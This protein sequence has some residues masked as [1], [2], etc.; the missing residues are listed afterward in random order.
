MGAPVQVKNAADAWTNENKPAAN[1]GNKARLYIKAGADHQKYAWLFFT[2]P[3]PYGA[4]IISAKLRLYMGDTISSSTTLSVQRASAKWGVNKITWTTQPATTGTTSTRNKGAASPGEMWEIDVTSQVQAAANGGVWFGLRVTSNNSNDHWWHSAQSAK[5]AYRP[6]LVVEW[7]DAPDEPDNL[8]PGGGRAVPSALPTLAW[9]FHDVSGDTTLAAAEVH[10]GS[11][12]ALVEAGNAEWKSGEFS[13]VAPELNLVGTSYPGIAAGGTQ[14][15]RVRSKDGAGLWSIWSDAVSFT[16]VAKG[17]LT[18]TNPSGGVVYDWTPDVSWTFSG[19]QRAYQVAVA[20]ASAPN[21]WLW[22]T[23][24]ISG[25]ATSVGIPAEVIAD[26]ASTY[27]VIVR[28]WDTTDRQATPGDPI[29]VEATQNFT[30]AYDSGVA[31]ASSLGVVSDPVKPVAHLS[32]G[33]SATPDSWTIQRSS[34]GGVTWKYIDDEIGSALSTGGS[35]YAYDDIAASPYTAYQWRVLAVVGGH[36]SAGNPVANGQVRRLAPFLMKKDGS[37]A[38]CFLNP[39][40]SRNRLDVQEY[41]ETMSG[42]PVLVTQKLG[43]YAGHVEGRFVENILTGVTAKDMKDRF[44]R[45]RNEPGT[46]LRLVIANESLRVVA[47]N[48]TYDIMTDTTGITYQASFDWI[49]VKK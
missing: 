11:T 44:E 31:P 33:R 35:G 34:D 5:G 36:Q 8:R 10:I 7:S 48:M 30:I 13:T 2:K 38:V 24:K 16:R 18:L 22:D 9:D 29:Y 1:Y 41:H 43:G 25:S 15:W 21:D 45:M 49:E 32:W 23:G 42:S 20:L 47:Y 40:R 39:Q 6:A 14:W 17:T 28:V 37:D 26:D 27:V 3:W 19:V 4:T 12:E 46:T